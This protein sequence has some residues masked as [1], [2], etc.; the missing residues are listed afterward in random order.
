M[1]PCRTGVFQKDKLDIARA[2]H[3]LPLYALQ[4]VNHP[5]AKQLPGAGDWQ[6]TNFADQ[7]KFLPFQ[8]M[9][10]CSKQSFAVQFKAKFNK[11]PEMPGE[12]EL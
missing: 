8:A 12:K 10:C 1:K 5:L 2:H 6:S 7:S 11:I 3:T 4:V 9:F